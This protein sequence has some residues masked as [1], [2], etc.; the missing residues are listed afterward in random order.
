MSRA[1]DRPAGSR[2]L[3]NLAHIV[4]GYQGYRERERRRDEDSRL[5]ARLLQRLASIRGSL[6]ELITSA[7]TEP[8]TNCGEVL[9][10]RAVRLD[11]I[12]DAIR[13]APYGFSGFF[14]ATEVREDALDRILEADLLL[15]DDLD[16]IERSTDHIALHPRPTS[17]FRSAVAEMDEKIEDFE[18]HLITRDKL[19]GDV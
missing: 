7:G 6:A 14:D 4:P 15:F 18:R 19:L 2:F 9:D 8:E 3:E 17:R 1:S 16:A 5:R 13:Y 12:A 10:R 11:G